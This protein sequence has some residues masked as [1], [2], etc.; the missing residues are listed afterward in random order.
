[1]NDTDQ[2]TCTSLNNASLSGRPFVLAHFTVI[3]KHLRLHR[4]QQSQRALFLSSDRFD[5]AST[6]KS[7]C[8]ART[9]TFRIGNFMKTAVAIQMTEIC[10]YGLWSGI[11]RLVRSC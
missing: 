3:L 8:H 7:E 10:I 9:G 5:S 6:S 11:N 1:M 2:N 4:H